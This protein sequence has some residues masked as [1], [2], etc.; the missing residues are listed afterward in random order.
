ML[1][2]ARV[3]VDVGDVELGTCEQFVASDCLLGNLGLCHDN[4]SHFPLFSPEGAQRPT[5]VP[6][7]AATPARR[8]RADDRDLTMRVTAQRVK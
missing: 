3:I 5:K 7:F 8:G 2:G 6:P 4:A 1:D